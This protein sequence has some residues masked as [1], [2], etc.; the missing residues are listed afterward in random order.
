[1]D[2]LPLLV[3]AACH[4]LYDSNTTLS[5]TQNMR[6]CGKSR[7]KVLRSYTPLQHGFSASTCDAPD[8][9]R[10]LRRCNGVFDLHRNWLGDGP[11]ARKLD[12][13]SSV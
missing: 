7:Q 4:W 2:A 3:A 1:M 10:D 8:N 6:L 11:F 5:V 13:P 12:A 9:Q